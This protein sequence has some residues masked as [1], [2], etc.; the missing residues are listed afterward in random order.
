V[1]QIGDGRNTP[2][3]EARWLQG[4]S[5]K[6]LAPNFFKLARFKYRNVYTELQNLN[7]IKNL[8]ELHTANLMHEFI[9][10]LCQSLQL[11]FLTK[12]IKSFEN[13]P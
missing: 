13:G 4:S 8:G 12:K 3:W 6:D 11:A 5:P 9:M 1:V 7:W 10:L 2:F